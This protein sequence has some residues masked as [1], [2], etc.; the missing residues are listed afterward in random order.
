MSR[1]DILKEKWTKNSDTTMIALHTRER[2]NVEVCS[3]NLARDVGVDAI[4][5]AHLSNFT[6]EKCSM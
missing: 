4:H 2:K 5:N 3:M 1:S 6:S